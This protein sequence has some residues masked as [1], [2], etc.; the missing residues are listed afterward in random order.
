VFCKNHDD[1]KRSKDVCKVIGIVCGL[2]K[3][4]TEGSI[5]MKE[6][7]PEIDYLKLDLPKIPVDNIQPM[8]IHLYILKKF[9]RKI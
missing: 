4:K 6:F 3:R 7:L 9:N 2:C 5:V 1:P 8:L